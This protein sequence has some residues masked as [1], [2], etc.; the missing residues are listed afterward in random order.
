MLR[1]HAGSQQAHFSPQK[2][3]CAARAAK[4]RILAA[5]LFRLSKKYLTPG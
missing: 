4:N 2:L 1:T 5:I 3:V